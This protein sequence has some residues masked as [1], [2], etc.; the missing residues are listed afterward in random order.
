MNIRRYVCTRTVVYIFQYFFNKKSDYF[1]WNKTL[2]IW[3]F[4]LFIEAWLKLDM[5]EAWL[6]QSSL[7]NWMPSQ[8]LVWFRGFLF[9]SEING[10]NCTSTSCIYWQTLLIDTLLTPY[11]TLAKSCVMFNLVTYDTYVW[12]ETLFLIFAQ[13]KLM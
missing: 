12:C 1:H 4:T 7:R 13:S 10:Y 2:W 5:I 8:H 11:P 9:L 3:N 6:K